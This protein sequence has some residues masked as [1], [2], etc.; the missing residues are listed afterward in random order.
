MVGKPGEYIVHYFVGT[1]GWGGD[2]HD[3][4][5]VLRQPAHL[6]GHP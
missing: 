1:T 4:K 6:V 3:T 5:L 2:Q